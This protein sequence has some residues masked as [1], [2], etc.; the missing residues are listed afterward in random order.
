LHSQFIVQSLYFSV[1]FSD[2]RKA[3][4][5][6]NFFLQVGE[7]FFYLFYFGGLSLQLRF[8]FLVFLLCI[9]VFLGDFLRQRVAWPRIALCR[10]DLLHFL[11]QQGLAGRVL[12]CSGWL[13]G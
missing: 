9:G 7:L 8:Y 10:L 13:L 4:L 3:L 5:L 6:L 12:G 11:L 2:A 1:F